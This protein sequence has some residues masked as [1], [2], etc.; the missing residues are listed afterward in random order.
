MA[1]DQDTCN[2][3][4]EVDFVVSALVV[5]LA[6]KN[7]W[8]LF[9]DLCQGIDDRSAKFELGV[10]IVELLHVNLVSE[11]DRAIGIEALGLHFEAGGCKAIE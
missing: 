4:F 5:G 2:T 8:L 10:G 6:T 3:S 7:N 1:G 9:V 11:N